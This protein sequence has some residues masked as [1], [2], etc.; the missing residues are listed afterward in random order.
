MEFLDRKTSASVLIIGGGPAGLSMSYE[1]ARRGIDSLILESGPVAGASFAAFPRNIFFG[2]WVNNLLPGSTV[3]WRW[4]L[5]RS[6]Q[7]SYARYLQEY[8]RANHL[9]I[10]TGVK[11]LAVEKHGDQFRVETSA[12]VYEAPLVVNATGYFSHPYIP[13]YPGAQETTIPQIH[14]AQYRDA[15]TVRN[16]LGKS[17]GRVLVVGKRLSAGETMCELYHAGFQVTLA[18][19]GKLSFGPSQFQEGLISPFVWLYERIGAYLNLKLN[20]YPRM[21]GGESRRLIRTGQVPTRPNIERFYEDRVRFQ[22]GFEE[23][24][25]LVVYATGYRAALD[26][27]KGLIGNEEPELQGMESARVPG[28]F[29]LGLDGLRTFR[30]RFLRGIRRDSLAL[31]EIVARKALRYQYEPVADLEEETRREAR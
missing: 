8:S 11:V 27:L 10:R 31:A 24:F 7:P 13:E 19:R 2:P 14:V 12:G 22:N 25:D 17:S 16:L 28:L 26:H 21:A 20:S 29:F 9:P 18:Y 5:N 23:K 6:T 1:L 15:N 3:H 30:S 4:M